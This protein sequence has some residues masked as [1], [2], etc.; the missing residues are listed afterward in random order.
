MKYD[1][2]RRKMKDGRKKA[3]LKGGKVDGFIARLGAEGEGKCAMRL[4]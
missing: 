1:E 3:R 2:G 4:G